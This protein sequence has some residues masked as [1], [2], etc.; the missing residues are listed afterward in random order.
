MSCSKRALRLLITAAMAESPTLHGALLLTAS[1]PC[2]VPPAAAGEGRDAQRTVWCRGSLQRRQL[3]GGCSFLLQVFGA[4]LPRNC[5]WR[6]VP[7]QH[8]GRRGNNADPRAV[9]ERRWLQDHSDSCSSSEFTSFPCC[10]HP[11]GEQKG[12][13]ANRRGCS[14]RCRRSQ[15]WQGSAACVRVHIAAVCEVTERQSWRK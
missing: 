13:R 11:S 8:G 15:G 3:P 2:S 5:C 1:L 12:L 4:N 6:S 10:A 7:G 14:W 9:W